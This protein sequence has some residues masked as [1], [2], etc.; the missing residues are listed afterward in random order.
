MKNHKKILS[1]IV[2]ALCLFFISERL[3][4][5][6]YSPTCKNDLS[7]TI[8]IDDKFRKSSGLPI[9]DKSNY[10]EEI[11]NRGTK[12]I[13]YN[14]SK[15]YPLLR[16]MIYFCNTNS[17]KDIYLISESLS[18]ECRLYFNESINSRFSKIKDNNRTIISFEEA[19]KI[20]SDA[21]LDNSESSLFYGIK[22]KDNVIE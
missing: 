1:I 10:K 5:Y 3:Y 22:I 13:L 18:I 8:F 9:F 15:E 19:Y 16:E 14:D 17:I 11:Q 2:L 4:N 20:L 6:F 21:G 12:K 7:E